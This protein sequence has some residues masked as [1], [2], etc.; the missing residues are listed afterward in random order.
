MLDKQLYKQFMTP[1]LMDSRRQRKLVMGLN[2][3]MLMINEYLGQFRP[4]NF[5][6]TIAVTFD[7]I[8]AGLT[9]NEMML[10]LKMMAAKLSQQHPENNL[11]IKI[12][13]FLASFDV[14]EVGMA[15]LLLSC[16]DC[17]D[18]LTID[19][20]LMTTLQSW[21]DTYVSHAYDDKQVQANYVPMPV[22]DQLLNYYEIQDQ[23]NIYTENVGNGTVPLLIGGHASKYVEMAQ[24]DF[25]TRL[26]GA[27]Y[28]F[29]NCVPS[30]RINQNCAYLDQEVR[31]HGCDLA[32][33]NL[34]VFNTFEHTT[35]N[36][37]IPT[38]EA[39]AFSIRNL[40][41]ILNSYGQA[42]IIGNADALKQIK[43]DNGSLEA[44]LAGGFI[45]TMIVLKADAS[46]MMPKDV[47]IFFLNMAYAPYPKNISQ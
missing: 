46:Q 34:G 33:V 2:L 10:K 30:K 35:E 38:R 16:I 23:A 41:A 44:A 5:P 28:Q 43:W 39:T 7:D 22:I 6:I 21:Y 37:Y 1:Y 40:Q 18:M 17:I 29:I 12:S 36:E 27:I 20:D 24:T 15:D 31:Q 19:D 9:P 8:F 45:E 4:E 47:T 3:S 13:H 25:V 42:A 11:F 26:F 32:I 14:A